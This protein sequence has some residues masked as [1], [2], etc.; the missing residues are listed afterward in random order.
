MTTVAR[1]KGTQTFEATH[2]QTNYEILSILQIT[3]RIDIN[4]NL[5]L[6]EAVKKKRIFYGQAP[7]IIKT[8]LIFFSL[9]NNKGKH[10][11]E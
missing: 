3:Q 1:K 7:I 6:R 2:L 4:V 11:A 10:L 5:N 9:F 8:H